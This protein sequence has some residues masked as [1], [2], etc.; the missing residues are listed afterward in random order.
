[1]GITRSSTRRLLAVWFVLHVSL[2]SAHNVERTDV[3][4]T[5]NP[6]PA[7]LKSLTVQLRYTL[8]AEILVENKGTQPLVV[9]D[10]HH[11]PFIRIGPQGVEANLTSPAWYESRQ[12][13]GE[14]SLPKQAHA[15]ATPEWARVS[16]TP[17]FGWF[18]R[19]VQIEEIKVPDAIADARKLAS[20]S[21]WKIPVTLGNMESNLSGSFVYI[22]PA[23]GY[24]ESRLLASPLSSKTGVTVSL[25]PGR[26]PAVFIGNNSGKPVVVYGR[27]GE[28]LLRIGPDHIEANLRS[29]SWNETRQTDSSDSHAAGARADPQWQRVAGGTRYAWV[30]FRAGYEKLLPPSAI[31]AAHRSAVVRHWQIPVRIGKQ[32]SVIKGETL[33]IP[34]DASSHVEMHQSKKTTPAVS[35]S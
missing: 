17:A 27:D 30:D 28:P 35:A 31:A 11:V 8:A 2:V 21:D 14:P 29:P 32:M 24:F 33:W 7:L 3:R 9:Y 22:P 15:G 25:T 4:A 19:R 1:M 26:Q 12:P 18:D 5:I 23:T 13:V 16:Q 20:F 6:V 10:D 34:F